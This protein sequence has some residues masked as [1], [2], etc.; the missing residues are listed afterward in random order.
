MSVEV[1]TAEEAAQRPAGI[2]R[3]DPNANPRLD[4]PECEL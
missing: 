4:P 2:G 1:L 3:S